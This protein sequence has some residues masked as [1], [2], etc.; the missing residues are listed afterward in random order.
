[1]TALRNVDQIFNTAGEDLLSSAGGGMKIL[2]R[3]MNTTD[4]TWSTNTDSEDWW[5]YLLK[6]EFDNPCTPGSKVLLR[7]TGVTQRGNWNSNWGS[8]I[9]LVRYSGGSF[10][11]LAYGRWS[12]TK[13]RHSFTS[14]GTNLSPFYMQ[15][16][17]TPNATNPAYYIGIADMYQGNTYT[18]VGKSGHADGEY[19]RG[20]ISLSI[21]EYLEA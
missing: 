10:N 6:T 4:G 8:R 3:K 13:A 7:A 15:W 18:Y 9:T 5:L 16:I 1:M 21:E 14:N 20:V 12:S 17:D 11:N 2:Q 19:G